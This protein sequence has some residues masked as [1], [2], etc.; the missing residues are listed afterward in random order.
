MRVQFCDELRPFRAEDV[1]ASKR[2]VTTA[3]SECIDSL[4]DQVMCSGEPAFPS[5]E[6]SGT[7]SADEGT[8]LRL[9][10]S[11]CSRDKMYF[12]PHFGEPSAHI[13]PTYAND[14]TTPEGLPAEVIA[15]PVFQQ[16]AI[17]EAEVVHEVIGVFYVLGARGRGPLL[18]ALGVAVA[19]GVAAN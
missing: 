3:Y 18:Y 17:A 11:Q 19:L 5:T 7:S 9:F 4:L 13:V 10:L 14:I 12:D 15:G 8:A 2:T 16:L 6:R 1:C